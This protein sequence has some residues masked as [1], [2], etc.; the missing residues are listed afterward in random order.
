MHG[1]KRLTGFKLYATSANTVVVP[2]KRTQHVG[3]KN[4]GCC[5]PSMLR[6][7]ARALTLHKLVKYYQLNFL[8]KGPKS[9][10]DEKKRNTELEKVA[11]HL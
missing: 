10:M 7:F 2:C 11:W 6:P 4:V 1:S 9:S 5:W 3:P 8:L